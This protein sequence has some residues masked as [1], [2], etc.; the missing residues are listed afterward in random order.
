[1][2]RV[3]VVDDD[4]AQLN[5]RCL[6]LRNAGYEVASAPSPADAMASYRTS[7]PDVVVMDLK[8]PRIED[9]IGLL[10]DLGPDARVVVLTG[11]K[12]PPNAVSDGARVLKKPCSCESLLRVIAELA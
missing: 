11:A 2:R 7:R 1:M 5:V 4:A 3:L 10:H 12:V 9:G 8:L 6:V